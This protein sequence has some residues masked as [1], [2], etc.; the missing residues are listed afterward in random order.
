M[1]EVAQ[2]TV[3]DCEQTNADQKD[4]HFQQPSA[5]CS[6]S[7]S[8]SLL[9]KSWIGSKCVNHHETTNGERY[10]IIMV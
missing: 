8:I 3:I 5:V 4:R 1:S 9:M 2:A 6:Q 7:G 10:V